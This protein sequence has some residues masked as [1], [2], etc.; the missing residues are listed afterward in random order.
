[1]LLAQLDV[2]VRHIV[3]LD[4]VAQGG[5]DGSAFGDEIWGS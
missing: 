2:I 1:M 5:G 3:V 4:F